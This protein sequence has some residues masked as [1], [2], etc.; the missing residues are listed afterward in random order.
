M[1]TQTKYIKSLLWAISSINESHLEECESK[2]NILK[3]ILQKKIPLLNDGDGDN[4]T[5][6]F[7]TLSNLYHNVFIGSSEGKIFLQNG[8]FK[9]EFNVE[10]E[11]DSLIGEGGFGFV[12]K[13]K[14]KLD[15][16][17][18][19]IKKQILEEDQIKRNFYL[20][21]FIN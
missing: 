20:L 7:E 19:A 16:R 12:Y 18:Y 4:L 21:A 15:N 6:D 13:A 3:N 5:D 11:D 17:L 2:Y 8:R 14:H 1:T 10:D 9:N